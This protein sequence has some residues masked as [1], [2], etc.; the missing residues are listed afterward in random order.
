VRKLTSGYVFRL[1]RLRYLDVTPLCSVVV[2]PDGLR[3]QV[4]RHAVDSLIELMAA[5]YDGFVSMD[6]FGNV[7]RLEETI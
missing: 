7:E 6:H 3:I 5:G 2:L 4:N 1:K